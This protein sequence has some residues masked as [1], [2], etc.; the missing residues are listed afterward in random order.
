M[1]TE[2]ESDEENPQVEL[3]FFVLSLT[4]TGKKCLSCMGL[5]AEVLERL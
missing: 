5:D 2:R 3:L 1:G 4:Y